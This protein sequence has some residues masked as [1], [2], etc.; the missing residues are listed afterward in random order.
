[1]S[2]QFFQS[3]TPAENQFIKV[4]DATVRGAITVAESATVNSLEVSAGSTQRAVTYKPLPVNYTQ[5]TSGGT[6]VTVTGAD[7]CF[8]ITTFALTTAAGSLEAFTINH[9]GVGANDFAVLTQV[10]YSGSYNV[11]GAASF[12]ITA[13]SAGSI[14]IG[15]K[16]WGVG[17]L[18][19]AHKF[20]IK[21][22]HN[23]A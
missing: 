12:E 7:E 18:N 21:I 13:V 17:A 2:A 23:A 10:S 14:Q 19:G 4:Q 1:M 9:S 22:Y 15:M 5:I 11:N 3:D 16:N 6:A 20:R 8:D